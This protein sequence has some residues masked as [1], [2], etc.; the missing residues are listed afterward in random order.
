MT[1]SGGAVS[2]LQKGFRGQAYE[3]TPHGR[4]EPN[5]ETFDNRLNPIVFYTLTEVYT[6]RYI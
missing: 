2:V 5:P 6:A 1:T 4:N 3:G